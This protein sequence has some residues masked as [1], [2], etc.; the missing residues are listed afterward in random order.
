MLAKTRANDDDKAI[1]V[2]VNILLLISLDSKLFKT[3]VILFIY[4]NIDY[5]DMDNIYYK[6]R[7]IKII[8]NLNITLKYVIV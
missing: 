7:Y 8:Y 1:F 2:K 3:C 4:Y 6:Y 5:N